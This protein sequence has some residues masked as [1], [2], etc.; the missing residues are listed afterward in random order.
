MRQIKQSEDLVGLTIKDIHE[1]NDRRIITFTDGSF[2]AF[3]SA[4]WEIRTAPELDDEFETPYCEKVARH[5]LQIDVYDQNDFD[6]WVRESREK[7]EREAER[8]RKKELESLAR[9]KEKY[10]GSTPSTI[11]DD[12]FWSSGNV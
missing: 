11:K 4:G 8:T 2:A 12:T 9:L 5:L 6:Q 3:M 1:Y 10:E 7:E